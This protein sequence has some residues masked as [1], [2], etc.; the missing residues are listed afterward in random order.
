MA[1]LC[2]NRKFHGCPASFYLRCHAY[3]NG[4]NCW[5]VPCKPCC[6][7]TDLSICRE[8][9]VYKTCREAAHYLYADDSL[10]GA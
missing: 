1:N 10:R 8:C 7:V 2:G 3:A 4:L 6:S 5:E 9:K